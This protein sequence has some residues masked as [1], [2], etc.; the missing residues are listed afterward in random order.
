[1]SPWE[2]LLEKPDARGHLVQ[3]HAPADESALIKNVGFYLAE[4]L[5]RGE[6]AVVIAT[7]SHRE[8]F[9]AELD[10][11]GARS[12]AAILEN[13]LFLVDAQETA[14]RLMVNGRPDWDRFEAV[15]SSIIGHVLPAKDSAGLRAYGEIV[16]VL[17]NARQFAAAI[18]L[19]QFWNKLLAHSSFKLYCSYQIDVMDKNFEADALDGVLS[20]H[21]HLMPS[22]T[23]G[24][25]DAAIDLA[26]DEILGAEA[27]HLK[28]HIKANEQPSWA[29]MPKGESMILALRKALPEQAEHILARAREHYRQSTCLPGCP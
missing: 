29:L 2:R 26:M 23:N 12:E 9:T 10:R 24:H 22:A 5:K 14:P 3:F 1:M 15:L 27:K 18:R 6:G 20:T 7:A 4:G 8:R 25:L 19:E 28:A 16:S 17:W 11:L 13:R 21:T